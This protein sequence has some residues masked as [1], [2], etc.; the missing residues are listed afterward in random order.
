MSNNEELVPLLQ[1]KNFTAL[2]DTGAIK[3][4]KIGLR[5]MQLSI[6]DRKIGGGFNPICSIAMDETRSKQMIIQ[7]C[8]IWGVPFNQKVL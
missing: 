3:I 5:M 6:G 2:D 1:K 4:E 7:L 8:Q